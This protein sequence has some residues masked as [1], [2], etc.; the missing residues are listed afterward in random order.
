[1]QKKKCKEIR[2]RACETDSQTKKRTSRI[3]HTKGERKT[4]QEG[5]KAEE[6]D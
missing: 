3:T 2:K 5:N 4:K 1:M 6:V